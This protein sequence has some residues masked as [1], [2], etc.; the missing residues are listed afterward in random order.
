MI[1]A[2]ALADVKRYGRIDEE[3]T[4]NIGIIGGGKATNIVPDLVTIEAMR[5]AVIRKSWKLSARKS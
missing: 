5:A 1:A 4:C 3:T 2:K